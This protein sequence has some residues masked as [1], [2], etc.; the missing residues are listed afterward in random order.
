MRFE[1]LSVYTATA[2][3]MRRDVSLHKLIMTA[4]KIDGLQ[5]ASHGSTED[6]L[7]G[8]DAWSTL[9]GID[10]GRIIR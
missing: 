10:E 6:C 4:A 7:Y 9:R 1:K 5:V 2:L 3:Q 8:L